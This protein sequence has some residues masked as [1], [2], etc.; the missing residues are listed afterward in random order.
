MTFIG[1][2][3][4]V[5]AARDMKKSKRFFSDWGL[6]K[7]KDSSAGAVFETKIGSQIILRPNGHK[8]LPKAAARGVD[9][10]EVVWGVSSKRDTH[11]I[12]MVSASGSGS[13]RTSAA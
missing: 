3:S 11:S 10:R 13:G 9:F 2:E 7:I 8:D 1:I 5:Y 4:V 6:K 12:R